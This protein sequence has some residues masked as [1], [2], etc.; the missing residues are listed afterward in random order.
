MNKLLNYEVEDLGLMVNGLS[1]S[2][3]VMSHVNLMFHMEP[4]INTL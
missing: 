2:L 3:D 1:N 4:S